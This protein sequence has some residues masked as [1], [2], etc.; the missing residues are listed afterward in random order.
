MGKVA[1]EKKLERKEGASYSDISGKAFQESAQRVQRP[2]GRSM[3]REALVADQCGVCR[4][5]QMTKP[6]I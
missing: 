6:R 1:F 2:C 3:S 5:V 4:E